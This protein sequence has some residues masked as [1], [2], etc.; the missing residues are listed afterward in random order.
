MLRDAKFSLTP[1]A[2]LR[3]GRLPQK[4]YQQ[5]IVNVEVPGSYVM[6]VHVHAVVTVGHFLMIGHREAG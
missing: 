1:S 5:N 6:G 3:R 2:S 4:N